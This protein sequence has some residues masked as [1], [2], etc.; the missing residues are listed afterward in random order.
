MTQIL[1]GEVSA[2]D[3]YIELYEAK[4]LIEEQLEEIRDLAVQERER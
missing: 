1:N 3:A 4:K 2:I